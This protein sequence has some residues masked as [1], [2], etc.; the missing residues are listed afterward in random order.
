MEAFAPNVPCWICHSLFSACQQNS[1][2]LILYLNAPKSVHFQ[3]LYSVCTNVTIHC[4]DYYN[5]HCDSEFSTIDP[6]YTTVH[7]W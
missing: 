5:I 4:Y 7:V 6:H 1:N 3:L 2:L